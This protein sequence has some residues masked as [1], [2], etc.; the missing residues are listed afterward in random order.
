[1]NEQIA[2]LAPECVWRIFAAICNIPHSSGEEGSLREYLRHTAEQAGLHCRAD[3]AGNLMIEKP[4]SLGWSGCRTVIL[5]S[6]LDMVP[7]VVAGYDFNFSVDAIPAAI[8]DGWVVSENTT[9]GADNGIGVALAMAALLADDFNHVPIKAIF[10]V[11]EE[12]GLHGAFSLPREWVSYPHMMINLDSENL[13]QLFVGC[14][15]GIRANFSFVPAW[16]PPP[17]GHF[18]LKISLT[19]L[20]GGHSG[21]D[22]HLP[23][24][25]A[26]KL[27]ARFF[28]EAEALAPRISSVNGGS[29]DNAIPREASAVCIVPGAKRDALLKLA[30][31][32]ETALKA[33]FG[34]NEPNIKFAAATHPAVKKT[35]SADFQQRLLEAVNDCR[36]GVVDMSTNIP[37]L[38][39][40]STN[41]AVINTAPDEIVICTSQR[42]ENDTRRKQLTTS[43]TAHFERY[44]AVTHIGSEYPGWEP[45]P[46]SHLVRVFQ[47][48][49]V[50]ILGK[51]LEIAAIHA[52][53]ECGVIGALNRN[54]EMVSFG[55]TMENVHA[56]GERVNIESVRKCWQIL[57][58]VLENA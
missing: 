52:G 34:A 26:I 29:R 11:E 28:K 55:P 54:L 31:D 10:T 41:L 1:M 9:L 5:Q 36:H 43:L 12:I 7:Q 17:P 38:V 53:L 58:H 35:F 56:P 4:A 37:G 18:T 2:G 42:S 20:L 46:D 33:E 45:Q 23:R 24:G 40:T 8:K 14:A 39:G 19:G 13:D 6:H 25:N 49:A 21:S 30:A 32:Y 47:E 3:E 57:R 22:I 48:A 16:E 51:E 50:K 44:G 27:L 15:G